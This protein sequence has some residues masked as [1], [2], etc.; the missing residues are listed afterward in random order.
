MRNI[1]G[2]RVKAARQRFTP[3]MTQAA[4]AAKLQ[5]DDWDIDRAGVG[6][7]EVS[8]REVRDIEL[9]KLARALEVSPAWLLGED[10]G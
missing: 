2:T 8:I 6:K 1:V 4:L 5:L 3:R 9:V 10:S 7:I